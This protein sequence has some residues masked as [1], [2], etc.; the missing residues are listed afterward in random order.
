[1][2]FFT[3]LDIF[4]VTYSPTRFDRPFPLLCSSASVIA[5][6][7]ISPN[8]TASIGGMASPPMAG[9]LTSGQPERFHFRTDSNRPSGWLFRKAPRRGKEDAEKTTGAH[10]SCRVRFWRLVRERG[11]KLSLRV[12]CG[13]EERGYFAVFPKTRGKSMGGSHIFVKAVPI[14]RPV[15][16]PC[17]GEGPRVDRG[18]C[19]RGRARSIQPSLQAFSCQA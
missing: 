15:F 18:S 3:S 16:L 13:K 1:M 5:S 6:D 14:R 2:R 8:A 7:G 10:R 19:G 11:T 4:T 17:A 12:A 9:G